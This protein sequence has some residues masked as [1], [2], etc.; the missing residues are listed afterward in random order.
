MKENINRLSNGIKKLQATHSQ[1]E[2]LTVQLTELKPRLESENKNAKIQAEQIKESRSIASIKE[3][4]VEE[5]V[6]KG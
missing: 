5:E 1:I 2:G 3:A 6:A 4:E